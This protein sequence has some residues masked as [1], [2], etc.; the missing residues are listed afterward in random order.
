MARVPLIVMRM[1]VPDEE[2]AEAAARGDRDAF[3]LLLERHYDGVFRLS[4]RLSGRRDWAEDLTQ[5]VCMALPRKLAGFRREA[6]FT[7]WLWRVVVNAV[8]DRRRRET[9]QRRAAD[10]WGDRELDRR[11]EIEEEAE[12]MGWL[13]AAMSCLPEDLRD[14]LALT[15]DG[16][17]T[18]A[19][20]AAVLGLS[21]GTVSW[22]LSEVRRRLKAMRQE[23]LRA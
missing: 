10:C 19:E 6:R 8:H 1:T 7:T 16:E 3:A 12:A 20:A 18:H 11:A 5:E 2:L 9:A 23:E 15:L 14:T 21:E 13:R 22:R 4:F 17:M